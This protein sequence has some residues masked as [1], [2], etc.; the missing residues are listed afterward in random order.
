MA[1]VPAE[2]SFAALQAR[3]LNAPART[4]E[5]ALPIDEQL[6]GAPQDRKGALRAA[7][8]PGFADKCMGLVPRSVSNHS[9]FPLGIGGLRKTARYTKKDAT[10]VA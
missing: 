2:P 5:R 4:G 1:E 8:M 7:V 3:R 6:I 9:R 10:V